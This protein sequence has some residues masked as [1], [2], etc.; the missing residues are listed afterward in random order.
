[1]AALALAATARAQ[2]ATTPA[3]WVAAVH[4]AQRDFEALRRNHLPWAAGGGGSGHCDAQIGRFCYWHGDRYEP[5]P[6]E[7]E[8]VFRA[9]MGLLALLDSASA[10]IPSDDWIAGQRVRYWLEMGQPDS[11]L[12]SLWACAATGWWCDALRGLA[13][14]EAGRDTMS[15]Q[16]FDAALAEM[17]PQD[18]CHWLDLSLLLH[19][20][21]ADRYR[22]TGCAERQRVDARI[23]W[24]ADPFYSRPG[25]DREA[26]HYARL[27]MVRIAAAS[28]WPE[29]QFWGDDLAELMV[30]YGW[31]R[32]FARERP[33]RMSDPSYPI[34][35]HDPQPSLA[36][37]PS[38]RAFDSP[39]DAEPA[40][41]D[42]TA[43]AAAS[44]YA[45][46]YVR[47]VEP[48]RALFSRFARGDSQIVVAAWDARGDSLLG[49]AASVASVVA[50]T[51]E[52]QRWMAR[53]AGA[54]PWGGVA[55]TAPSRGLVVGV[56]LLADSAYAA[57]RVR[58]G[59]AA[60]SAPGEAAL[61]DILFFRPDTAV[62]TRL[63]E[64]VP[65]AVTGVG[66]GDAPSIG[67]Y[68]ELRDP[69]LDTARAMDVSLS[70]ERTHAGWWDRTRRMFHLGGSDAPIALSWHDL[71]RPVA[72][73]VG[74]AVVVDLSPLDD[75]VYRV[76]LRVRV[77]GRPPFETARPLTLNRR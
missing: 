24:L 59:L 63:A 60:L 72:G 65:R 8:V 55:V 5:P 34:V 61:S 12:A 37:L 35:G 66:A 49:R 44:R 4:R 67:M 27:V 25:N 70:I 29:A 53:V 42:L 22:H 36:F 11:A 58:Q 18:R 21:L 64:V 2:T 3:G 40:D 14:H 30:R 71:A 26:E 15:L 31:A 13:E 9:R 33:S 6:V 28:V 51:D 48:V 75:G 46:P 45:P 39:V 52:R 32:W 17:P 47:V 38:A 50:T 62:P 76:R 41:W 68:W 23:W 57:G 74:R 10:A 77:A 19:G 69:A 20:D 1:M 54:E 7:S 43:Y 16:A 73:I 56:E